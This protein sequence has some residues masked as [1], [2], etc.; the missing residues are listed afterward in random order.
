MIPTL[1]RFAVRRS[2][3]DTRYIHVVPRRQASGLV[4]EVYRQVERD[5]SMLAPPTA[6]HSPAPKMLAAS[7]MILRETLLA[8][9]F[10]DRATKEAVATE[11]S[12]ANS[13]PYCT[14]V[15]GMTLAAMPTGPSDQDALAAWETGK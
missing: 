3:R 11:V 4:A 1:V 13:C 10:A 8:Q 12:T 6:L 9:G 15:H 5:F 14:D 7:W 2:L